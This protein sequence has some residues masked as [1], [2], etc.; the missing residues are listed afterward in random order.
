MLFSHPVS[1]FSHA[2]VNP[3]RPPDRGP[4]VLF[5]ILLT[6][7]S[8][9]RT[10]LLV[11]SNSLD[12]PVELL[13]YLEQRH[14]PAVCTT[15]LGGLAKRHDEFKQRGVKLLGLSANDV[16]SHHKWIKDVDEISGSHLTVRMLD[17]G[18]PSQE[19]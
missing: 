7:S 2:C 13:A 8:F 5:A 9:D 14:P 15:E 10:T 16:A 12:E 11:R 1:P 6:A 3:D 4:L 17:I 18:S 19:C